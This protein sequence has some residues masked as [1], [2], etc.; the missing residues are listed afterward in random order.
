MSLAET[1]LLGRAL[2][3]S[4]TS[5]CLHKSTCQIWPYPHESENSH[6]QAD[7]LVVAFKSVPVSLLPISWSRVILMYFK[8]ENTFFP[9]NWVFWI[10]FLWITKGVITYFEQNNNFDGYTS[11]YLKWKF[12]SSTAYYCCLVNKVKLYTELTFCRQKKK[13]SK[14]EIKNN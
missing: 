5:A 9:K 2:L 7:R 8:E 10:S 11:F 14:E 3:I 6:V 12:L 1:N 13:V 4:D